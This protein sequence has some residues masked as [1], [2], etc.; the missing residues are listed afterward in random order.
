MLSKPVPGMPQWF[1]FYQKTFDFKH[2]KV[3]FPTLML[4]KRNPSLITQ[5]YR[6]T[7]AFLKNRYSLVLTKNIEIAELVKFNKNDIRDFIKWG[8]ALSRKKITEKDVYSLMN[9]GNTKWGTL[10][11]IGALRFHYGR[12]TFLKEILSRK[13]KEELLKQH[14]NQSNG[15]NIDLKF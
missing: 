1:Y 15:L 9:D 7:L 11:K 4:E 12:I 8:S 3:L 13:H 10:V 6:V 2:P 5:N 14:E